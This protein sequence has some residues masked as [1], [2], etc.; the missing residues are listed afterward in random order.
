LEGRVSE[1]WRPGG[2][3]SEDGDGFER[4]DAVLSGAVEW[5]QEALDL[6]PTAVAV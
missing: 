6:P 2:R 3:E 1:P 4:V 5:N